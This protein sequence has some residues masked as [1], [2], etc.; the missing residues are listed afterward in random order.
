[1][2]SRTEY[3]KMLLEEI[4]GL[5]ESELPKMVKIVQ[6]FK[7]IL[8]EKAAE[9]SKSFWGSFG[10]WEDERTAEEIIGDIYQSRQA[11]KREK[12]L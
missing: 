6:F 5:P 3:E 7:E 4:R 10:S 8:G 2:L 1:M 11:R 9:D 12:I